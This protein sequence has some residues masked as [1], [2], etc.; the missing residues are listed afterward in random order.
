MG[1]ALGGSAF[2]G[3]TKNLEATGF[4]TVEEGTSSQAAACTSTACFF[5][6]FHHMRD[7]KLYFIIAE[8]WLYSG[9][10]ICHFGLI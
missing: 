3:T 7:L 4:L 6:N 1:S 8:I 5:L 10:Q 9:W 2:M